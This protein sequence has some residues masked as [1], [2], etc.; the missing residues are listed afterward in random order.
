MPGF[1]RGTTT[2]RKIDHDTRTN[3]SLEEIHPRTNHLGTDARRSEGFEQ[4]QN[5]PDNQC[6]REA[7]EVAQRK[8]NR[9]LSRSEEHL[10][11]HGQEG[12]KQITRTI[13]S[14][15]ERVD[16]FKQ[17]LAELEGRPPLDGYVRTYKGG[18]HCGW[19]R[20]RNTPPANDIPAQHPGSVSLKSTSD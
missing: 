12:Y 2:K 14:Q 15:N 20:S 10:L 5:H 8:L 6:F 19:S 11:V 18:L 16:R 4:A 17:I 3:G 1:I 13:T 9:N 7:T